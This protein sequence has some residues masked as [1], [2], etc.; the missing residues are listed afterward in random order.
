MRVSQPK[1]KHTTPHKKG[2]KTKAS[3]PV[4]KWSAKVSQ[5]SDA[6]DL[7]EHVFKSHDPTKIAKS[8]KKSAVQSKRKKVGAFQ[9]AMSM[10]N[11]YI[12][13]AGTHLSGVQK[14]VLEA[15]KDRL[16]E[17]FGKNKTAVGGKKVVRHHTKSHVG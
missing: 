1:S 12:N 7:K 14:E 17:V 5:E 2:A 8:L 13:R 15:T 11:F 6:L 10:L 3:K 16:R 9:S 4:K